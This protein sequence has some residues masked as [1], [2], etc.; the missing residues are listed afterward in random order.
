MNVAMVNGLSLRTGFRSFSTVELSKVVSSAKAALQGINLKG[1]TIAVGGF[2]LGGIP[3]TLI[4][5]VV[6]NDTAQNLTIVSLTAGTDTQGTG[7]ILSSGKVRRLLAAYVGENK[8]LE[9]EYF[10]G[11]L[12]VELTPMGTIAERLRAG[13]AG[14]KKKKK[15][16][17]FVVVGRE[18]LTVI[19]SFSCREYPNKPTRYPRFLHANRRWNNIRQRGDSSSVQKRWQP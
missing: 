9:Q 18:L 8:Y 13:G 1:A 17:V 12:Q 11:N 16:E 4:T 7:K 3:E 2:G 5:A 10:G 14:K 19:P 6:E 15:K